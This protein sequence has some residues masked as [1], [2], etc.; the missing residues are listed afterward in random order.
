[1]TPV[2]STPFHGYIRYLRP[3][4][5]LRMPFQCWRRHISFCSP[6]YAPVSIK[7]IL[8]GTTSSVLASLM[9]TLY[10]ISDENRASFV[11]SSNFKFV[12]SALLQCIHSC[13]LHLHVPYSLLFR[14]FSKQISLFSQMDRFLWCERSLQKRSSSQLCDI[15]V[16]TWVAPFPWWPTCPIII[17]S[18]DICE[19]GSLI[20]VFVVYNLL[21]HLYTAL[22]CIPALRDTERPL[23]LSMIQIFC[24]WI[25]NSLEFVGGMLMFIAS[26][27]TD[28]WF[29]FSKSRVQVVDLENIGWRVLQQHALLISEDLKAFAWIGTVP[30]NTKISAFYKVTI[31]LFSTWVIPFCHAR[32]LNVVD[33][34]FVPVFWGWTT[35]CS[36]TLGKFNG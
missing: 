13:W 14:N 21:L 20:L 11:H 18:Y 23:Q 19:A 8:R 25:W 36:T 12:D 32:S 29:R 1:M 28:L 17:L 26:T 31:W 22:L 15:T 33:C 35:L 5:L 4:K 30:C 24:Y 6:W 34:S 27:S 2:W 3:I 9:R 7:H 16:Y 10:V